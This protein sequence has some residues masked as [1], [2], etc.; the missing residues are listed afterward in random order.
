M[1]WLMRTRLTSICL[2]ALLFAL[3]STQAI[4]MSAQS[5]SAIPAEGQKPSSIAE[6]PPAASAKSPSNS[7]DAT[8]QLAKALQIAAKRGTP[9]HVPPYIADDLGLTHASVT[10]EQ[11][12][13]ASELDIEGARK[14]YLVNNSNVAVFITA[15]NEQTM[16]YLVRS[17]VLKKAGRVTSG[18]LGSKSLQNVPLAA[19]AAGFNVERDFWIQWIDTNF[20]DGSPSKK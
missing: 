4:T 1:G 17:G 10:V 6:L 9:S 7:P 15:V 12:L 8:K 19:A 16:V 3:V 18:R 20:P 13:W 5:S 2:L 11:S 14:I